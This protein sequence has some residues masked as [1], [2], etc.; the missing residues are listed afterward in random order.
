MCEWKQSDDDWTGGLKP[1]NNL[2]ERILINKSLMGWRMSSALFHHSM[3]YRSLFILFLFPDFSFSSVV[4]TFLR[5][6]TC[7]SLFLAITNYNLSSLLKIKQSIF[8]ECFR[9]NDKAEDSISLLR[10]SFVRFLFSC[11][12]AT[13]VFLSPV[14]TPCWRKKEKINILIQ[15]IEIVSRTS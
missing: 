2:F 1:I 4:S 13:R 12:S 14:Y 15:S 8:I 5:D 10:A 3:L 11:A 6:L 9:F 7:A